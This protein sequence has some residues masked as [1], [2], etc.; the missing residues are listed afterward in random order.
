MLIDTHCHI[1]SADYELEPETVIAEA[2]AAGVAAMLCVGTDADDSQRAVEFVASR[3]GCF[4][5]IGLHPHDAKLGKSELDKLQA[6]LSKPQ[7]SHLDASRGTGE[8][9][10]ESYMKYDER[11]AQPATKPGAKSSSR[12]SGSAGKQAAAMRK[13][14]AVGECG[15]DYFYSHSPREEQIQAFETQIVLALEHS[16]PMIFHVRD[17]FED[18]WPVF[19]AHPGMTG[20]VHSFSATTKELDEILKR[21]L[22]VG[23]NGIMTF[24]SRDDQLAAARAVPLEKLLLE[25]DAPFLTPV[26]FRGKINEPKYVRE[27]AHFLAALR[28]ESLATLAGQTTRNAK[29]L[30]NI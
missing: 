12:V 13:V 14:V 8:Q 6:L 3:D 22:Y 16:L 25:T 30:F 17:A 2:R 29:K 24:T 23:L 28:G 7:P 27:V 26:P 5:T 9:R 18:F 20:V 4:A 15:L 19:D 11:A 21:G 10:I 1:H